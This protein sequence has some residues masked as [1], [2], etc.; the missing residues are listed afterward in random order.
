MHARA[1]PRAERHL[2]RRFDRRLRRDAR[3]CRRFLVLHP[4]RRGRIRI[5]SRRSGRCAQPRPLL[6]YQ[7]P[8]SS[9]AISAGLAGRGFAFAPARARRPP[10][11]PRR[12][13]PPGRRGRGAASK[14]EARASSS[15][16]AAGSS[17]P[18]ASPKRAISLGGDRLVEA[19]RRR[20]GR[21][22]SPPRA[23]S[24]SGRRAPAPSRD[25]APRP[26]EPSAAP[27]CI[28]PAQE[29]R[30]R[31]EVV[32]RRSSTRGSDAPI[33]SRALERL[34]VAL[35]VLARRRRAPRRSARARSAPCRRSASRGRSS[36]S[37]GS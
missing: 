12:A 14:P 15:T 24:R 26:A 3:P 28:A 6:S 29:R 5:A 2:R 20:Q 18:S 1:V 33:S 11:R 37:S 4:G 7:M 19:Q 8:R 34:L 9:S 31:L 22:R 30:P 21:A 10:R 16:R 27:A 32:R 36:V 23:R 35:R 17:A 13:R 25:R